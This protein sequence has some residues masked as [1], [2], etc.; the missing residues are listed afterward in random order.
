M[1]TARTLTA[2]SHHVDGLEVLMEN[3]QCLLTASP[4]ALSNLLA[5]L[6]RLEQTIETAAA[7]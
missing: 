2:L 5:R 7:Q 1:T 4:L 3:P 6:R